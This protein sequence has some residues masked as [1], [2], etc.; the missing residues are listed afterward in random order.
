MDLLD[1]LLR[2]LL[3]LGA[4]I[5]MEGVAWFT[6]KYIMHGILWSWHKDHHRKTKGFFEKNDLFGLFFSFIA[7]G[8]I[9]GG[10]FIPE[11][12]FATYLGIGVSMY[13]AAYFIFHDVIVHKRYYHRWKFGNKY[14]QKIIKVHHIHHKNLDKDGAEAF[15]FLFASKKYK[16]VVD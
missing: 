7:M 2:L 9:F 13:G 8:L 5:G 14:M 12:W 4:F 15:G 16:K 3:V 1:I 11:V 10:I 6:H